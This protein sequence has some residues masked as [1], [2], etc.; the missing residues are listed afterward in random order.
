MLTDHV[1]GSKTEATP[2]KDIAGV[3]A[4]DYSW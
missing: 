1:D 2:P 3:A 4:D